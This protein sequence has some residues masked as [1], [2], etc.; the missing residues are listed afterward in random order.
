MEAAALSPPLSRIEAEIRRIRELLARGEFASAL[1]VAQP[2]LSEAPANRD[3]LYMAA[4]SQRYLRRIPDALA[5]LAEMEQHHPNYARLYQERGHCY[6]TLRAAERAI[7]A[8]SRAV[9]LNSSLPA[10]WNALQVLYRMAGRPAEADHAA[11]QAA[12]LAALPAEIV[13]A[14]SMYADGQIHEAEQVVRQ[15]LLTH[16]NHVEGMRLLAEIGVKMDVLDDAEFLLENLLLL[17][18]NHH[19]ARCEYAIVLLKR[20]KHVR[21]REEIDKLLKVDPGNTAYRTIYATVCTGFGHHSQALPLYQEVLR[22]TPQEPELHLSIAHAL[23]TL[24]RTPEAIESYRAAAAVRPSFG[25]AYWSLAN[26]KT[27]RFTDA[28]ISRMRTEEGRKTIAPADRYHLCFAIG[29]ALEDR[30]EYAE[31]YRYYDRGNALK[32]TECLYRPESL[33][34]IANQQ[35]SLCTREFFAARR[36]FGSGSAAP[37]FIIGLPRSGSTLIEQI[38][39]SHSMVEG[40]MELADIPRL[41]QDLQGRET[42]GSIP[43]YPGILEKLDADECKRMGERYLGDTLVYRAGKPF[44]IDKMPNNFRHLALIHLILPNARIIDA[45][46]EPL[47][48]CFSNFKQLFASG[49]QF[50]YSVEDITRYYRMYAE[51][52]AHW[53]CALPGKIL[54]VDHE[55]VVADLEGNVRRM[56]EFCG[57]EFEPDCV[58]FHQTRRSVH[59]A[60][61]E[62]VRQPIFKDGL[63]QWRHFDPWLGDFK[64]ALCAPA[65]RRDV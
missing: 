47:A 41:V 34:R 30:A 36:G 55:S 45:R 60:S 20:H 16:G 52:M 9:A 32:K 49:Q 25:E 11:A 63:D 26:L 22:E 33:E 39:A 62:Q 21:A 51:L 23:K 13:T 17:A 50:T 40:T 5:T 19:V 35:K 64:T 56:L 53:E 38:L 29:K 54:R 6:V 12:N 8:F 59:T 42:Q 14:F 2:L 15:Y 3:V 43:R 44:F 46:R 18:P 61:S 1:A 24:G 27:Y 65:A 37:I 4:V 31:S 48:C 7:E 28:E 10:S 57:L 58:D